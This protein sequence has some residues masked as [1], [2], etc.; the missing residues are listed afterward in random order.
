MNVFCLLLGFSS[1]HEHMLVETLGTSNMHFLFKIHYFF[2]RSACGFACRTA[3]LVRNRTSASWLLYVCS[4]A[5][6]FFF[7]S[8]LLAFLL[9]LLPSLFLS[10]W[11]ICSMP[12]NWFSDA[13]CHWPA[14]LHDLWPA[15]IKRWTFQAVKWF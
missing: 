5:L 3:C 1:H 6:F 15:V 8:V 10:A 14:R 2:I 4:M 13:F 12:W 7:S 11:I 9:Y